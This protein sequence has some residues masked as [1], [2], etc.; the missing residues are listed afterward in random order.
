MLGRKE[1]NN[2]KGPPRRGCDFTREVQK[3]CRL[4]L[5]KSAL[6]RRTFAERKATI[7][8]SPPRDVDY[9]GPWPH[10][11]IFEFERLS[12]QLLPLQLL[13]RRKNQ[14]DSLHRLSGLGRKQSLIEI[15][16]TTRTGAAIRW[17]TTVSWPPALAARRAMV[18]AR[19]AF[20]SASTF[21]KSL[22]D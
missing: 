14:T 6:T 16:T 9:P 11:E 5:R 13:L 10:S 18:I 7:I 4:L 3:L 12:Y 8:K 21:A 1:I 15:S 2:W 22:F 17:S 20:R 19:R